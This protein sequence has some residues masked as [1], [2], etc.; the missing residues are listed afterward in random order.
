MREVRVGYCAFP[1]FKKSSEFFLPKMSYS[2]GPDKNKFP[3][4][5]KRFCAQRI[6]VF[7]Q[8]EGIDNR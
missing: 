8:L 1:N 7:L 2:V 6:L 3:N 5:V 4:I